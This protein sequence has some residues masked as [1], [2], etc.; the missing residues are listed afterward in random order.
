MAEAEAR[1]VARDAINP[2]RIL[3]E[4]AKADDVSLMERAL[5]IAFQPDSRNSVQHVLDRGLNRAAARNASHVLN[6]VLDRG[7]DIATLDAGN[8]MATDEEIK[9]SQE[10]LEILIAHGWNINTRGPRGGSAPLLWQIS[11]YPDLVRW[12]LDHGAEVDVQDEPAPVTADGITSRTRR[13]LPKILGMAVSCGTKESFDMLRA[14]GAPSDAL[15]LHYAVDRATHS[16]PKEGSDTNEWYT[17]DMDMTRHLVEDLKLDVNAVKHQ[18]NT[19]C[20]TPLCI[21]ARGAGTKRD[22]RELVFYLLDN[23]ADLNLDGGT[24]SGHHYPNPVDC[25]KSFWNENFLQCVEEWNAHRT[26]CEQQ[27]GLNHWRK[28]DQA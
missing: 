8:L 25:A 7:A 20:T 5:E 22:Y 13:S 6:Y 23:G 2:L 15:S 4:A 3:I 27:N 12:C 1:K 19:M 26:G 10:V 28:K 16:A 18:L 14:R 24:H 9:P 21:V 11:E 17:R